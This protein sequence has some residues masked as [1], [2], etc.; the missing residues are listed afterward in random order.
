MEPRYI[1]N[2]L[3][4][5]TLPSTKAHALLV[6][7]LEAVLTNTPPLQRYTTRQLGGLYSG[8]TG[9]AYLFF[10]LSKRHPELEVR[11]HC[12]NFWAS[13]YMEGDRSSAGLTKGN[14]GLA[15]EKLSFQALRACMSGKNDDLFEFLANIPL[16]LGPYPSGDFY[17][18][19]LIYGRAGLLYL[20]RM[21]E[22]YFP[23]SKS[24]LNSP[25]NCLT[26]KILETNDDGRGNWEWRGKRYFGAAHGEIG[27][28][29]QLVLAN[30]KIAPRLHDRL[31]DLLD[32]QWEDGNWSSSE[33]R[34]REGKNPK[35]VQW[36][37]GAPGFVISLHS[38]REHFPELESRIDTAILRAEDIIWRHG[39]L[40]KEPS[41]C[42][43]ILG[44]ALALPKGSKRNHFLSLATT[45]SMEKMRRHDPTLFE[46]A[47]YD[48]DWAVMTNYY[49]S[50]AWAW[51]TL[52][53]ET[54][55]M[56]FYNDV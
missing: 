45:E 34:M 18:S 4:T 46:P 32:L 9:I 44:N 43:G 6:Q 22:A 30:P 33:L 10:R 25:K 31:E 26:K 52:E 13:K 17:S 37:H 36:C 1:A 2:N 23:G 28:I 24:Y 5:Q 55:R 40:T 56:I 8:Y 48:K 19:E 50:A 20:I 41:L 29:T 7:S 3:P 47:S 27:I 51:A 21:I 42:H 54:P 15:C 49:T 16:L 38:L 14:C 35:L 53:D 11:G 39:L 12:L